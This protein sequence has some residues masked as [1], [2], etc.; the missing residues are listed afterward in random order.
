MNL[1]PTRLNTSSCVL[2][3]SNTWSNAM[4]A[5]APLP[6]VNVIALPD[7][8]ARRHS[9]GGAGTAVAAAPFAPAAAATAAAAA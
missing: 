9:V 5:S 6:R 8:S 2:S 3:P 4:R 1:G 7:A